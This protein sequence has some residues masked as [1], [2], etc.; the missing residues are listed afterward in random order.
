MNEI[1]GSVV[2]DWTPAE[3][4]RIFELAS[5]EEVEV[6]ITHLRE[7]AQ[8]LTGLERILNGILDK[9][10]KMSPAVREV[11]ERVQGLPKVGAAQ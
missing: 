7:A 5:Y 10:R 2:M 1:T 9:K 11:V 4:Q 3:L 6:Y 8:F